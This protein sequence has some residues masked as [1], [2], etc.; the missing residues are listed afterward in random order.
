[1]YG[2]GSGALGVGG[3]PGS[4]FMRKVN[5]SALQSVPDVI[6]RGIAELI[7][8]DNPRNIYHLNTNV[9]LLVGQ[10]VQVTSNTD[11]LNAS[12]LLVS[13]VTAQ[14]LGTDEKLNSTWEYQ[15]DLGPVNRSATNILSHIFR[16]TVKNVSPPGIN[17]TALFVMEKFGI[18]DTA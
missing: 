16:Q 11:G 7:Q 10:G 12:T 3:V 8:Y 1:M 2:Y 9:E 14:W 18:T 17:Q 13:Q 5:D 4:L 15:A 6:N